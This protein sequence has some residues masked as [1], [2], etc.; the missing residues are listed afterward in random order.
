MRTW[1]LWLLLLVAASAADDARLSS[2]R[3]AL[4]AG[5]TLTI[6]GQRLELARS[7][8]VWVLMENRINAPMTPGDPGERIRRLGKEARSRLVFRVEKRWSA[9]QWRA[10][11]A[12][13]A[14]LERQIEGLPQKFAI[15]ELYSARLSRK[16]EPTYVA[17]SDEESRRVEQWRTERDRLRSR[18]VML[19]NYTSSASSLFGAEREGADDEMHSVDPPEASRELFQVERQLRELCPN[20]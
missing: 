9:A 4:P 10:A 17:R 8:P 16:G 11:R 6:T 13:N 19:P 15:V 18:R 1:L 20:P 7:G 2:L 14:E 12:Q 3:S 5:W